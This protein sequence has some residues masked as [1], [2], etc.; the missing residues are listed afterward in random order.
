MLNVIL[1]L[2]ETKDHTLIDGPVLFPL[3]YDVL[4]NFIETWAEFIGLSAADGDH[5]SE[6]YSTKVLHLFLSNY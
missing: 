4:S 1:V 2:L 5:R 6:E 3:I